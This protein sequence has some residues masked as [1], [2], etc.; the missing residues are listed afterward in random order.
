MADETMT[1]DKQLITRL[2]LESQ[3]FKKFWRSY[4]YMLTHPKQCLKLLNFA[5]K[6]LESYGVD[7]GTKV[8]R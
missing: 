5:I 3:C 1:E 4:F 2:W 6:A 8:K 7:H